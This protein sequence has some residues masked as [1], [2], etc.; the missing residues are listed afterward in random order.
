MSSLDK[1]ILKCDHLSVGYQQAKPLVKGLNLK[2]AEGQMWALLGKNGTGKSTLVKSISGLLD[3]LAGAI[4]HGPRYAS[5]SRQDIVRFTPTIRSANQNMRVAQFLS[6]GA[7][8]QMDW[9]GRLHDEGQQTVRFWAEKL[10][11]EPWMNQAIGELSDGQFQRVRICQALI[12]KA[13]LLLLD[14]PTAFLDFQSREEVLH[15]L[16]DVQRETGICIFFSTHELDLACHF[17]KHFLLLKGA[18]EYEVIEGRQSHEAIKQKLVSG[19]S[20]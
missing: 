2:L 9:L 8:H 4:K 5:K 18:E 6:L 1:T 14:E 3:P 11:I 10:A 17:A 20:P 19:E 12:S 7:F 13:P 15:L 16:R